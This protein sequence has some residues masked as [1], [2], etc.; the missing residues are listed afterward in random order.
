MTTQNIV[1]TTLSGQ[2]GT[3]NF[4][5]SISPSFTT[6]TIGTAFF[7]N[8]TPSVN[9]AGFLDTNGFQ[10]IGSY[11]ASGTPVNFIAVSNS[12]TGNPPFIVSAGTDTNIG[13]QLLGKGNGGALVQGISAGTAAVA[14]FLGELMSSVISAASSVT[15]TSGTP[16]DL[17]SLELTAGDW[18]VYGNILFTGTTTTAGEVWISLSSASTPDLSLLNYIAP[19]AT[20]TAIGMNAPFFRVNVSSTTTVYLSGTVNGTGTIKGQG[21]LYARRAR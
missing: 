17:T 6:P 21:G 1:N 19:I 7:T 12:V 3:G 2:T 18:D 20:S 14:G 9:G 15:F 4:A 8:L 10:V 11:A 13:L 5:G 16:K